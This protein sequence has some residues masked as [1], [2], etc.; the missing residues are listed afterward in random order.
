MVRREERRPDPD[1][2]QRRLRLHQE[3]GPEG[4]Q[5]EHPGEQAS[6]KSREHPDHP[7]TC[8]SAI[9]CCKCLQKIQFL[10]RFI[11]Y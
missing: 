7:E 5:N 11:E 6:H 10:L 4:G 2:T 8:F 1:L 3:P 9:Y